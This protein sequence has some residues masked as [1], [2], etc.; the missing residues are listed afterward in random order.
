VYVY[1]LYIYVWVY[2]EVVGIRLGG[3][4]ITRSRSPRF[5]HPHHH[6]HYTT[7]DNKRCNKYYKPAA[8]KLS[9]PTKNF[10]TFIPSPL[11]SSPLLSQPLPT[12]PNH[13]PL[14]Q[15]D[16]PPRLLFP[17]RFALSLHDLAAGNIEVGGGI[18][19]LQTIC[20]ASRERRGKVDKERDEIRGE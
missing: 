7:V 15:H 11:L 4:G 10:L 20:T 14:H 8:Q 1:I 12:S 16:P 5:G 3:G 19:M 13:P 6:Y 18:C 2:M 17:V 9:Q